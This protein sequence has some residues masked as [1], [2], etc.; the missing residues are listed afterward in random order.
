MYCSLSKN[1]YVYNNIFFSMW[2]NFPVF[3]QCRSISIPLTK[4]KRLISIHT[5]LLIM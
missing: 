4:K 1:T 2:D 5:F 3:R